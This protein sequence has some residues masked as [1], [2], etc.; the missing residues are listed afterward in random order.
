MTNEVMQS[1]YTHAELLCMPAQHLPRP[2]SKGARRPAAAGAMVRPPRCECTNP[3]AVGRAQDSP[4]AVDWGDQCEGIVDAQRCSAG[5]VCR[6]FTLHSHLAQLAVCFACLNCARGLGGVQ[7]MPTCHS[8]RQHGL[9]SCCCRSAR[10]YSS[11]TSRHLQLA[12]W[13]FQSCRAAPSVLR[14]CGMRRRS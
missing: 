3:A 12:A 13:T 1:T 14:C 10:T 5:R 7:L 6:P 4:R 11:S 8:R 9:P 2:P